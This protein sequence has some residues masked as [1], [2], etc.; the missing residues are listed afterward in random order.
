MPKGKSLSEYEKCEIDIYYKNGNSINA[1]SRE[2]SRSYG[3]VKEY[4]KLG[5][6][7]GFNNN[8]RGRKQVL[9]IRDKRIVFREATIHRRSVRQIQKEQFPDISYTT[10]HNSL[11][12]NEQILFKK[13]KVKPPLQPQH[14]SARLEFAWDK[15]TWTDEWRNVVFSDEKRF[16]L[17]GPDGYSGYW[18]D[19]RKEEKVFS[20]RQNGNFY[21]ILSFFISI[22][23][24]FKGGGTLMFWGG[25]GYYGL[26][27]I[28]KTSN[29][30]NATGYQDILQKSLINNG[31][32]ITD[33]GVHGYIFQQDNASIH[34][35]ISTR[36]Y[37]SDLEN[38]QLLEWP[39]RSPD[40]NPMENL[41]GVLARRVYG[42]GKQYS[43]LSQL[44]SAVYREWYSIENTIL[45][46]L[47]NSMP[48]R[49]GQVLISKGGNT[50]Y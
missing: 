7:Y 6:R 28:V 5:G 27:P 39:S 47:I 25:F 23:P 30:L 50:K 43:T 2:L 20:A 45:E 17:D 29:K 48:N 34:T 26:L 38:V 32:N 16:N 21:H 44:E 36:K 18:H 40:L 11:M 19:L 33:A 13:A 41:W 24:I 10:I 1:I 49:M 15:K 14:Y 8:K 35:A 12:K 31:Q 42:N 22:Y 46:N 37:I 3:V 4:I 9:T